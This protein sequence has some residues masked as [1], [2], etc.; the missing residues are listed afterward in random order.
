M[1]APQTVAIPALEAEILGLE[2]GEADPVLIIL[3]A[4]LRLRHCRNCH[5]A[6]ATS[7]TDG[8]VRRI[9][10]ARDALLQ[11]AVG[12]LASRGL[13]DSAAGG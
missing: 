1:H 4:Q 9:V 8:D 13:G 6:R 3:A 5:A 11:R 12:A 10:A 7:V 2:P